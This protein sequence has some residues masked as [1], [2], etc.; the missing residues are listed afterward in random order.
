MGTLE[1]TERS[2][3]PYTYAKEH[4]RD[5]DMDLIRVAKHLSR[6]FISI[7]ENGKEDTHFQQTSEAAEVEGTKWAL[8]QN[9][10]PYW[11]VITAIKL[12]D[13]TIV[14][15]DITETKNTILNNIEQR[16]KNL[17]YALDRLEQVRLPYEER[18]Y[19]RWTFEANDQ[20]EA[21]DRYVQLYNRL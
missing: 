9:Q 4:G 11:H 1:I 6:W 3:S 5:A 17:E 21:I 2:T 13:G 20:R 16:K 19:E 18:Q 15:I 10:S 14:P 8:R 7:D 12:Q